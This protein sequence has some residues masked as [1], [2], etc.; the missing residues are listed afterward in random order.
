MLGKL[1]PRILNDMAG[2]GKKEKLRCII[3]EF[4]LGGFIAMERKNKLE[5]QKNEKAPLVSFLFFLNK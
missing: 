4:F 5:S 3:M 2:K 1:T